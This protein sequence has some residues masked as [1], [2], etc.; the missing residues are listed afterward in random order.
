MLLNV[1]LVFQTFLDGEAITCQRCQG[2]WFNTHGSGTF[3]PFLR[4]GLFSM[5]SSHAFKVG[6]SSISMPAQ[7]AAATQP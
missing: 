4:A 2:I 5:R 6:K 1:I 7:P 3:A